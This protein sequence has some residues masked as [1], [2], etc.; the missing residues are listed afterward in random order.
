MTMTTSF[1]SF[2]NEL[3]GMLIELRPELL[4]YCRSLTGKE[5]EAEDL[6]QETLYR[7]LNRYDL[8]TG[9]SMSKPYLFRTARN[10]WIDRCRS[11]NRQISVSFEDLDSAAVP[12]AP[13]DPDAI[14][15]RELL[16]ELMY[17]LTPKP[18]VIVLL[19]DIFGMTAK[20]AGHCI[21]MAEGAVQVALSRARK[22]LRLLA[23]R[24]P[25][26]TVDAARKARPDEGGSSAKL[27]YAVTT[28]FRRHDPKLIYESYLRLF[29]NGCRITEIR[30]RNGRFYFTFYD[31]DGNLLMVT[32]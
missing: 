13:A 22:R 10:L 26:G 9:F 17:R 21:N 20:E 2:P 12:A 5:W 27:L 6:V 18:F 29:E 24:E 28:A 15:T 4:R 1:S 19:C 8:T 32:E 16:E 31:P 7:V 25:E 14:I 11:G 3:S 30:S 23:L